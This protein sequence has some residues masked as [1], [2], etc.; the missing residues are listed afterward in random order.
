ML[1]QES[2]V[3]AVDVALHPEPRVGAIRA[4]LKAGKHVLSQK[5]FAIDLDIAENLVEE[6]EQRNLMLAVNQNGRWSPYFRWMYEAVRA[7]L[8]GEIQSLNLSINWDHTWIKGTAFERIRQI[9]LFD[10][11]VHWIDMTRQF[12]EE[13]EC[14]SCYARNTFAP[15][16]EMESPMIANINLTNCLKIVLTFYKQGAW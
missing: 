9:I 7:G 11:A 2:E 5:P 16:Q 3:L 13:R 4:C 1:A 8:I 14:L 15:G 12:F 10:F 6:A